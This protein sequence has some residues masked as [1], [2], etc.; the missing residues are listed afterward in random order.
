MK[1]VLVS[2]SAVVLALIASSV[3]VAQDNL[4]VGTWKLN[5]SKSKYMGLQAP[6]S[7]TRTV[8][9][10]GNGE[11]IGY[12]GIAGD[13]SPIAYSVTTNLDGKDAPYSGEGPLGADATAIKRVDAN[14]VTAI[15]RKAGRTVGTARAVVS[16]DGKVTTVTMKGTNTQGQPVSTTTIWDKQ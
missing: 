16:K 1:L 10:Q 3:L 5:V 9:A 12:K 4:F 6:K 8:V 13:G 14:T 11:I 7:E 2:V 15:L